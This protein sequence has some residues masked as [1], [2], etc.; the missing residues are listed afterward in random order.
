[1]DKDASKEKECLLE[2]ERADERA[3]N[4]R[5]T[6][7]R[8]TTTKA[9]EDEKLDQIMVSLQEGTAELRNLLEGKQTELI[10]AQRATATLQTEKEGLSTSLQLA[11]SRSAN[12]T[13]AL[14]ETQS[15]IAQIESEHKSAIAKRT[16]G[17]QTM[18][19]SLA[20]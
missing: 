11:Q 6:I 12:A 1:M 15:R 17:V 3:Q 9:E 13:T 16:A 8:L 19:V 5:S 2:A 7:E 20:H 18:R 14:A 4:L 10:E